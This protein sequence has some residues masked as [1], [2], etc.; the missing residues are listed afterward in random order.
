MTKGS[1]IIYIRWFTKDIMTSWSHLEISK[2]FYA[3]IRKKLTFTRKYISYI[4]IQDVFE[5]LF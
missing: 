1:R 2:T 5:T 4:P 3:Y